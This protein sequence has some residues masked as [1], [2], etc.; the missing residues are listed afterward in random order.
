MKSVMN[1]WEERNNDVKE[2]VLKFGKNHG[3]NVRVLGSW[4]SMSAD[5]NNRIKRTNG[6]W[7]RDQ[8]NPIG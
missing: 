7:W 4:M 1:K 8:G 2:E 6:L 3:G 5:V